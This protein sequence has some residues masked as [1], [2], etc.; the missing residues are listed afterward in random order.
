GKI[1]QDRV[2]TA[3]V[4]SYP[5]PK[6]LFPGSGRELL[7]AVG[8]SFYDLEQ[9]VGSREFQQRLDRAALMAVEDQ[10]AAGIDFITDGEERRGHYV[11]YV[12]RQLNGFDFEHLRSTSIRDGAYARE[13]PVVT[14]K[15]AYKRPITSAGL[16][17][18]LVG[19]F[20][21]TR[22]HADGIAKIGLPGPS[23][24]VDCVADDYYG[25]D[26][27][28]MA[29][30]YATAIRHEVGNLMDAG[31]QA[32]QF[33]DPVL[34]RYPERAKR[35]G[36]E[37]LQACFQGFEERALFFVHICAGYPDKPLERKGIAYKANTD[38][39][40]DI[41]SWLGESTIDVVS[42][43]GAQSGLDLS[44]LPAIGDKTVMLGVLDV[45]SNV[46]ESLEYVVNRGREAL[47]YLPREQ[48]ILAPDCGM[49]Q[50]SRAAAKDKLIR[51][52]AAA[53]ELNA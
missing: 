11:L 12:L 41:L 32:I 44:V 15:I 42:I 6:Y 36:L 18:S 52:A 21:F 10:N 5:K 14:G 4:G 25:G 33:D 26:L 27:E 28:Q 51:I 30:D 3:I 1:K 53:R 46:V 49:L 31:C 47:Q 34:L 7:D 50:L 45:G 43:E 40:A 37:A 16:G 38:Y 24:V 29:M 48:L 23:T 8:M 20:Q 19:D 13:L 17:T 35:W 9:E 39:Y 22:Q 2:M